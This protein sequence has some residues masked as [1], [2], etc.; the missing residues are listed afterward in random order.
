MDGAALRCLQRATLPLMRRIT[1]KTTG[2][3]FIGDGKIPLKASG[4]PAP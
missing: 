1:G 2:S 4:N 3:F